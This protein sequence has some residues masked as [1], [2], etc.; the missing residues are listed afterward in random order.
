[1]K[2]VFYVLNQVDLLGKLLNEI[3]DSNINGGT[4]LESSGMGRELAKDQ[5]FPM[6]GMLR[7]ILNPELKSTKTLVF[8]LEEDKVEILEKAIERVVGSLEKPNSGIL[9]SLPI[10][11][12]KGLKV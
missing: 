7:A 6:F 3:S 2:A 1:M 12:V 8:V 10:D 11:Y 5:D 4:I 9:F